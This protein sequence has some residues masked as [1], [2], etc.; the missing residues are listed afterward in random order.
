MNGHSFI[1]FYW[2]LEQQTVS[3]FCLSFKLGK[4]GLSQDPFHYSRQV[5]CCIISIKVYTAFDIIFLL[6]GHKYF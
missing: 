3:I 2:T 5:R 4:R 1:V 6:Q